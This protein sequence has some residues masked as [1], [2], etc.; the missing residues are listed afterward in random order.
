MRHL[1]RRGEAG[2]SGGC[3]ATTHTRAALGSAA[4]NVVSVD[5]VPGGSAV[6]EA[7]VHP[8]STREL[9]AAVRWTA[10]SRARRMRPSPVEPF[11]VGVEGSS[12]SA[13]AARHTPG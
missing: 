10:A 7:G 3:P 6:I 11:G 5:R 8:A 12:Q 1:S 13:M 9:T 2:K 4:G